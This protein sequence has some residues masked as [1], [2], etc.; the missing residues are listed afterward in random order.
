MSVVLIICIVIAF[1][2]G[3]SIGA[4]VVSKLYREHCAF[5]TKNAERFVDLYGTLFQW[6]RIHQKDKTL[7]DYCNNNGF[8]TVAVYG[9]SEVG[10]EVVHELQR[11]NIDVLY[12]IDRNADNIFSNVSVFRPDENL[13]HV[14]AVIVAVVQ[15]Y[16][17]VKEG[18]EKK[19]DC[20]IVSLEDVVWEV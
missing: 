6:I 9:L 19:I 12:C 4:L 18:L 1:V 20:P 3:I 16:E 7:A 17:E 2:V 5:I 8:K 13:Q 11:N 15:F 14:D 10:Y